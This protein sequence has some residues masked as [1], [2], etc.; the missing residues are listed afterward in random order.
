MK[1]GGTYAV[2]SMA[3]MIL[4]ISQPYGIAAAYDKLPCPK[5]DIVQAINAHQYGLFII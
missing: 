1:E 3:Y 4:G 2:I 5:E